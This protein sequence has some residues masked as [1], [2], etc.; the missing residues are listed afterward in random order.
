[1]SDNCVTTLS[2]SRLFGPLVD[3]WIIDTAAQIRFPPKSWD[4]FQPNLLCFVLC[5]GFQVVRCGLSPGLD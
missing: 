1:M 4:F 2:E 3:N 5:Y